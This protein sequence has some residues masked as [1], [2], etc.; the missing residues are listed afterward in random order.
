MCQNQLMLSVRSWVLVMASTACAQD[1]YAVA[2]NNYKLEFENEWVRV[3]RVSYRP[4]DK[5][6]VH[7]HPALPTVYV[8]VTD[9]GPIQFGHQEF[10]GL[11]RPSVQAGQ[12]RFNRGN[13]ETHWTEYLGDAPSEYIRLELKTEQRGK[14]TRDVRIAPE[15]PKPFENEQVRIERGTCSCDDVPGNAVVVTMADRKTHWVNG[16]LPDGAQIRI[17]L[18]SEPSQ[19]P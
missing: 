1:P 3:S 9:G 14:I 16:K 6:P 11:R 5:L 10:A 17:I 2:S 8:Y 7:D 18:K 13:K 19:K 4:G 15:D 12:I